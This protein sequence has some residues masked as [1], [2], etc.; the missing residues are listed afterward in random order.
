MILLDIY[1]TNDMLLPEVPSEE[2]KL[3]RNHYLLTFHSEWRWTYY[4]E[5]DV[6]PQFATAE[7]KTEPNG[8]KSGTYYLEKTDADAK[9][10]VFF[11]EYKTE[12]I[13]R[14]YHDLFPGSYD[15]V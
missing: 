8:A 14:E 1:M 3:V 4:G 11:Y 9:W 12:I 5:S 15:E 7:E 10:A 2:F 13:S 6:Y